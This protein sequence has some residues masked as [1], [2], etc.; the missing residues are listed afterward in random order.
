MPIRATLTTARK[1]L[2]AELLEKL[3]LAVVKLL[4]KSPAKHA[5]AYYKGLRLMGVDGTLL[6]CPERRL[7]KLPSGGAWSDD[8]FVLR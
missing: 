8:W 5:F 4:A 1:R 2:S 3:Y 6:G 7:G